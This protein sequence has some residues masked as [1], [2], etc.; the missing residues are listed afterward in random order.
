MR[1][2]KKMMI[3]LITVIIS[4]ALTIKTKT[5]AETIGTEYVQ[6][7]VS[8][9][10]DN[11]GSMEA[12]NSEGKR[13]QFAAYALEMLAG[14]LNEKDKLVITPMNNAYKNK[15]GGTY[16]W[17]EKS[18]IIDMENEDRNSVINNIFYYPDETHK[19]GVVPEGKVPIVV[20]GSSTPYS[21]VDR[22]IDAFEDVTG[23][24]LPTNE[25]YSSE[26][27]S[28]EYWLIILTDGKLDKGSN[29]EELSEELQQTLGDYGCLNT[30][31]YAF[32]QAN[33][34]YDLRD[35]PITMRLPF[36]AY[37]AE[38]G[39]DIISGMQE[40]ANK[41][42]RR[43]EL[44]QSYVSYQDNKAI[45]NLDYFSSNYLS[46]K[47]LSIIG[48]NCGVVLK[49]VKYNGKE[50]DVQRSCV[51]GNQGIVNMA[52]GCLALL[53][54]DEPFV[55]GS[56]ELIFG[57][58][59]TQSKKRIWFGDGGKDKDYEK[60]QSIEGKIKV[61]VEPSLALEAYFEYQG[62]EIDMSFVNSNLSKGDKIKPSFRI[63]NPVDNSEITDFSVFGNPQVTVTY[64]GL[65]SD[66]NKELTLVV[67]RNPIN[68][69]VKFTENNYILM[70]SVM[71][72]V[73]TNPTIYSV[74]GQVDTNNNQVKYSAFYDGQQKTK[75]ELENYQ[76]LVSVVNPLGKEISNKYTINDK[77][78]IVVD[79]NVAQ[80]L[81]GK[82]EIVCKVIFSKEDRI[83]RSNKQ[84]I[85]ELPTKIEIECLNKEKLLIGEFN[86]KTNQEKI[87]FLV[88][89]D[90][91]EINVDKNIFDYKIEINGQDI[92]SKVHKSKGLFTFIP[93]TENLPDASI[94]VKTITIT[95]NGVSESYEFEIE[96]T[97]YTIEKTFSENT[98]IDIYD[99]RNTTA[100]AH[101]KV[102]RNNVSLSFAEVQAIMDSKELKVDKNGS[103]WLAMLPAGLD[104]TIELVDGEPVIV[105]R[106]YDDG[107]KLFGIDKLSA[108]FMSTK[109][110]K[111]E[112]S[113]KN[114]YCS[115]T[116]TFKPVST[117][118][119][120]I[121]ILILFVY[122]LIA[123]H[124]LLYLLGFLRIFGC[125]PFTPGNILLISYD[126]E[127][128]DVGIKCKPVNIS[129]D[130]LR[131]HL[132]RFIPFMWFKPQNIAVD[133]YDRNFG[134]FGTLVLDKEESEKQTD[135]KVRMHKKTYS[136]TVEIEDNSEDGNNLMRY[137]SD[138]INEGE[139]HNK[140][141]ISGSFIRRLFNGQ[142]E[143]AYAGKEKSSDSDVLLPV[144]ISDS[145]F[146][147]VYFSKDS[148]DKE[149][150]IIATY[151][152][153]NK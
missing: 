11:S 109:D 92:T 129:G 103:G 87:S 18:V 78:E 1:V 110:K 150:K 48:Q 14:V 112:L 24:P 8:V 132:K 54:M 13:Y 89:G 86:L 39:E 143:E 75:Q 64:N 37:S 120:V 71:C 99:L 119:R 12:G 141:T 136:A 83:E 126:G 34:I 70:T 23:K 88:K 67:G 105:C 51:L 65:T 153:K 152:E 3:V 115:E 72:V 151:I 45:V 28:M 19:A 38:D 59:T 40:I 100:A 30:I 76:I 131:W 56:I 93:N 127:Y 97:K 52:S 134:D 96:E 74:N 27:D 60:I 147:R 94:G 91:N 32:G 57:A 124:I 81:Y 130:T 118:S 44:D 77:G 113:Y 121:K 5:N 4:I 31:Y 116:F 140:P 79:V 63:V 145:S 21:A 66:I 137:I 36:A 101:F 123:L 15:P 135:M 122:L 146:L 16:V 41:M 25:E 42:S 47:S 107:F 17:V 68:I 29:K 33:E 111:V 125:V 62:Q 6:K 35:D 148:D 69:E 102:Y 50:I 144:R 10:Y 26:Y 46:F 84:V 73:E 106:V 108:A 55:G 104:V 80:N 90:G 2:I 82:Y 20:P 95:V 61:L 139:S 53:E 85:L 138:L 98:E 128:N 43:F 9:V 58:N 49:K 7:I 133:E 22:A 117:G 149:I 142:G 114:A